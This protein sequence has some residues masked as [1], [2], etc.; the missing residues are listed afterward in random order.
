V[1]F[2]GSCEVALDPVTLFADVGAAEV[3]NEV[4]KTG[5][6]R[7]SINIPQEE[8]GTRFSAELAFFT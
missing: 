3:E 8:D 5:N 2:R 6:Y 7:V 4:C 1:E